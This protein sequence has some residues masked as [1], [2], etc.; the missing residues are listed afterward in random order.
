MRKKNLITALVLS[1]DYELENY[2]TKDYTYKVEGNNEYGFTVTITVKPSETGCFHGL[3]GIY[4][5][6]HNNLHS[7][8]RV[9]GGNL[10]ITVF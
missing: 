6:I 8:A 5:M 9:E 4:A 3:H 7:H 2:S 1:L 10:V